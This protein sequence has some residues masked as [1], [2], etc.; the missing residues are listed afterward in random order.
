M[1]PFDP[2][3]F[4]TEAGKLSLEKYAAVTHLSLRIYD[5]NRR[6]I[7]EQRGSNRLFELFTATREPTIVSECL[8]RCFAQAD[9]MACVCVEH[10][11]GLALVGAP[12]T[13]EN[14][15]VCVSIA[16]YAL[17]GHTD[18]LQLRRFAKENGL[19]FESL[20]RIVRSEV[21]TPMHRLQLNGEL[22]KIIGDTVISEHCRARQLE[23][24]LTE[25]Q[26]ANRSK[27]EF[28]ATLSHELRAP[29]NV[30]RGWSN[31]LLTGKL[32]NATTVHALQTIERNTDT[33]TRLVN[34]LLDISRIVAGKL[35]LEVEPIDLVSLIKSVIDSFR[36]MADAK[37]IRFEVELDRT[38]P[39]TSGDPERLRQIF[40]NLV[41]NALKFTPSGG[42]ISIKLER[43]GSDIAITISDTGQGIRPDFLPYVFD[44]FR[45]A[46]SSTT[47][48]HGGLGLGLAI[49]RHLVELHG[50]KISALSKGDG[51]GATFTFTLPLLKVPFNGAEN[52]LLSSPQG[53]RPGLGGM[54]VWIIDDSATGR[55][56]LKHWLEMSGAQVTAMASASEALKTLDE[57]TPE[58][59]LSDLGMPEM[60]GYALIRE[61][62]ARAP[63]HGGN[64]PAIAV[65]GYAT[66]EDRERALSAGFQLHMAKPL[67]LDEVVRAIATLTRPKT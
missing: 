29:L 20:W 39:P 41:S 30:I 14:E 48:H 16:G 28:L 19:L 35:S 5:R 31:I 56:M 10:E 66:P 62:R 47:R 40:F 25:L 55:R 64:V 45:Q 36:M 27:D 6:I 52:D 4:Q 26:A 43:L 37:H 60:D 63:E 32:D 21:P 3:V 17:T 8:E 61:V 7:A 11:H 9:Q 12:L 50:G 65:S 13:M 15:L 46:E 57:S 44:R 33:Q 22:L 51:Q 59:L 18:Q 49:V 23:A 53:E 2:T 1:L 34:D 67:K 38:L 24:T 58:V 42:N 54:R